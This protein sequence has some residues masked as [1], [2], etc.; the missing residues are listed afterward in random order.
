MAFRAFDN[1]S[2][3][4]RV[5]ETVG[6]S[7]LLVFV[8][9]LAMLLPVIAAYWILYLQT[10]PVP[11][12]DDYAEILGFAERYVHLP[13]LQ[14]KLLHIATDQANEYR[15]IF[16]QFVVASELE[17]T[18]RLN[19]VF[20][21]GLGNLFLLPIGFLLWLTYGRKDGGLIPPVFAFVPICF[22]FFSLPY[23]E[24]LNW[25]TADLANIPVVF[26]GFL[27]IYLLVPPDT[28]STHRIRLL[29]ACLSAALAACSL[30]NGFFLAPV[31][32]LILL[33]RR[34]YG[35]SLLWCASFAAPLAAY[36]YH[37]SNVVHPKSQFFYLT[38]PLTFLG[39][40]GIG[41]IP[42]RWPAAVLGLAMLPVLWL[43]IR[44]RFDRVNPVA[45]YLMLWILET[46]AVVAWVRG[47]E[48]FSP[49]SRYSIYSSLLLIFCYAFLT[50]YLS[51]RWSIQNRMRFYVACV[52]I[53]VALCAILDV[54]AYSKLGARRHMVLTGIEFYRAQP[55]VNSPMIDPL[56]EK[57]APAE[58]TIERNALTRAIQEHIYT[59][60]PQQSIQ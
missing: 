31:G 13:D 30:A 27:A 57:V 43:A 5:Y 51:Q 9:F 29:L 16:E 15:L 25:A 17:L 7:P 6:A 2:G 34:A 56:V 48:S 52:V 32:L 53:S 35:A 26:F 45:F 46:A 20:L 10:L 38:R 41:A 33:R 28:S 4:R 23:W 24:A 12:Q 50:H 59:L 49:A 14:A 44:S 47:Q 40:L 22:I 54:M 60:P 1:T 55:P 8:A 42:F 18:Q 58:K 21:T 36:L 39:F 3:I 19:F 11:Y 37:F